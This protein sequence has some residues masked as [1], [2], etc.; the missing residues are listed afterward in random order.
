[1][2]ITHGITTIVLAAALATA[3]GCAARSGPAGD[4]PEAP[5]LTA[6][7]ASADAG[8][9][10]AQPAEEPVITVEDFVYELPASVAPGATVTVV[11]QGEATHTVTAQDTGAF[12][13]VVAGGETTT[14]TAPEEPGEYP[15]T[16]AYHPEMSGTLVVE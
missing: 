12:E 4:T 9:A 6:P 5:A 11:N 13:A 2:N 8:S 14:F 10:A 15:I 3:T 1:M 7:A 16:C